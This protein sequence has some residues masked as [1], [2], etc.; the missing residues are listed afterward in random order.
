MLNIPEDKPLL[1]QNNGD[2]VCPLK[3]YLM[4]PYP[5]RQAQEDEVKGKYNS[6]CVVLGVWS[7]I[8]LEC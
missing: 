2:E 5:Y 8:A 4:W 7:K 3:H 6:D 1:E